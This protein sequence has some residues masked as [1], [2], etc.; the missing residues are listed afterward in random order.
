MRQW[1]N[2]PDLTIS[3]ARKEPRGLDQIFVALV[4]QQHRL[5]RAM[6]LS[7]DRHRMR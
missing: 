3:A 7:V 1:N 5:R 6:T 2:N 4:N